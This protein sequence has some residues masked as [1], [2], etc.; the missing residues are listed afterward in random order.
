VGGW[1]LAALSARGGNVGRR[2]GLSV[3]LV[4]ALVL[5]PGASALATA[6][7]PTVYSVLVKVVGPNTQGTVRPIEDAFV[8]MYPGVS[9]RTNADGLAAPQALSSTVAGDYVT[10]EVK[11]EG[12]RTAR[13]RYLIDDQRATRAIPRTGLRSS[14]VAFLV[15]QR[16]PVETL[17]LVRGDD[18]P[19]GQVDLTIRVHDEDGDPVPKATVKLCCSSA[20]PIGSSW[21]SSGG[22]TYWLVPKSAIEAGLQARVTA[23]DG[24]SKFSDISTSVLN[25]S[26]P[27]VFLVILPNAKATPPTKLTLTVNGWSQTA[28]TAR[29]AVYLHHEQDQ[30]LASETKLTIRVTIDHPLPKGWKLTVYHNGDVLSQGNGVWHKVCEVDAPSTATSCGDTRPG[31]VGPFDDIVWAAVTAPTY[32]AMHSDIYFHF[33]PP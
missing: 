30:P 4:V 13:L 18:T 21:T 17:M 27:R 2:G 11:A 28:T 29:P 25:G 32:L 33:N 7:K 15:G 24:R 19:E 22:E 23:P 9:A 14:L 10:I 12:Y 31:R 16:D 20:A 1:R 6:P 3:L 8:Q 5:L 26:G